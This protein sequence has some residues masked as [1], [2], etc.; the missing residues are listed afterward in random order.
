[1]MFGVFSD[2]CIID[3]IQML[4]GLYGIMMF[5][6][7]GVEVIKVELFKMGDMI[8]LSG[9]FCEGDMY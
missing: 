2:I 8:W 1:M 6:D 5:V 4:V 3:L 9:F 7:Y